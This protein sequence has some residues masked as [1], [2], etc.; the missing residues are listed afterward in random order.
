VNFVNRRHMMER[1][2]LSGQAFSWVGS[3]PWGRCPG[4]NTDIAAN[5][6]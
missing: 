4:F 6:R 2:Q 3:C 5:R 1:R